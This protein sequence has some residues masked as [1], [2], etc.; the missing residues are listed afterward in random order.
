[1]SNICS[2]AN[3][4]LSVLTRLAKVLPF[5][6]RQ[7]FSV[8]FVKAFIESRFKYCPLVWIFR[9]R[10]INDKINKLNERALRI[11]YYDTIRHLK[12]CWLKI[13][14]LQYTIKI[15]NHYQLKSTKLWIICQEETLPNFLLEII[16]MT[17]LVLNRT[18]SSK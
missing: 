6:K 1:M 7:F 18:N 12:N 16:T 8:S 9:G 11:V 15:F 5:K 14:L 13:K 10:Q 3:R 4:K 2:K 17:I